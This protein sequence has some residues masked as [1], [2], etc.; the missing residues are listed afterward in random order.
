M[1]YFVP[2]AAVQK[3][4]VG[5]F[6]ILSDCASCHTVPQKNQPFAGGRPIE[7]PFGIIILPEIALPPRDT[8]I[9]GGHKHRRRIGNERGGRNLG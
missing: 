7:T 3:P 5:W 2:F 1:G 8:R 6:A 9:N 4:T